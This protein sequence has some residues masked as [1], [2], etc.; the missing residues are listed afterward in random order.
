MDPRTL[1]LQYLDEA[2]A[3]ETALVTN[4][5]A[6]IA[7]ATE[8]SYRK[9]LE[10]HLK[11][12]REQVEAI[13]RRR[14]ELG[15]DGGR[16]IVAA[17]AGLVRDAV[18]Q[19]LVLTKGPIDAVRARGSAERMLKNAKDECATEALEIATYD[20]L[21]A[22]AEAA[23]DEKTA[24][25][26]RD[27][28]ATEE[29]TLAALREEIP[30]L[31]RAVLEDRTDVEPIAPTGRSSSG[32]SRSSSGRSAT[33]KARKAKSGGSSKSGTRA[34][35]ASGSRAKAGSSKS[36][37]SAGRSSSKSGSRSS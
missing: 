5:T 8:G 3:T 9:L 11:E 16:G 35:S 15:D 7:M 30:G 14:A 22:T 34:K 17:G 24:K 1:V 28:R 12:T 23:G 21:E 25:L 19:A 32:S 31:A 37:G 26:A 29:K 33:A 6:H 20:A 13:D 27:H 36:G 10:R 4:L 18:G 2:H